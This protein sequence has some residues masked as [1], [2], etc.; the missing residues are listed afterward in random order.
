MFQH[1]DI[2]AGA[3][4][5]KTVALTF[6]DG[7]G[8]ET[9]ELSHF[10]GGAGVRA[11]FF[12][13]GE[14]V[15]KYVGVLDVVVSDGHL[16]GNHTFN[17]PEFPHIDGGEAVRQLLD[18]HHLIAPA[19][20]DGPFFFRAPWG[21]WPGKPLADLLNCDPELRRYIGPISW[22]ANGRDYDFWTDGKSPKDCA[23][24]YRNVIHGLR[25]GGI[26]LMHDNRYDDSFVE[27]NY[28]PLAMVMELI[29]Q[30]RADGYEFVGM[31]EL[32]SIQSLVRSA[33]A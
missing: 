12:V 23:E 32:P 33:H 15:A 19:V 13:T 17:H 9:V 20:P 3:L 27:R 28:K 5:K 14:H 31:D 10:L 22:D 1:A 16:V 11:V 18:T 25:N 30:L 8:P 2:T 21:K 7:P 4:Q 29:P 26:V 6:D 24:N